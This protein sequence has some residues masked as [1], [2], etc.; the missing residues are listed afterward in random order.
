MENQIPEEAKENEIFQKTENWGLQRGK[1]F[2]VR[3]LALLYFVNY[4][5][6]QY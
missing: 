4:F 3:F 2:F 5:D 1:C 6:V